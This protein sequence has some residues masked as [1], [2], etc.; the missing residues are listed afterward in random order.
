M[1]RAVVDPLLSPILSS[2][3]VSRRSEPEKGRFG[4]LRGLQWR[5]NL[6]VLPSS[7]AASIDD[8]RRVTADCRR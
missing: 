1:H 3:S 5:I 8:L 6:G 4:D 2:D 7:S